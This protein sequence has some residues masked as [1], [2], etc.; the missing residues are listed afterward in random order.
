MSV[1]YFDRKGRPLEGLEWA[2]LF[3]DPQQ[4]PVA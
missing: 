2:R 1:L 3:S 4:T